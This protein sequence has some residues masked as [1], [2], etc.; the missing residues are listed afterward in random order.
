MSTIKHAA[1]LIHM[2]QHLRKHNN[3]QLKCT[4]WLKSKAAYTGLKFIRNHPFF[5]LWRPL[6]NGIKGGEVSAFT[7]LATAPCQPY[8]DA[9]ADGK[10]YIGNEDFADIAQEMYYDDYEK[11]TDAAPPCLSTFYDAQHVTLIKATK[12]KC[13][14]RTTKKSGVYFTINAGDEDL[15]ALHKEALQVPDPQDIY[16]E[17]DLEATGMTEEQ[18][19]AREELATEFLRDFLIP[20]MTNSM[21]VRH[22]LATTLLDT[23]T[24]QREVMR[25]HKEIKKYYQD[26]LCPAEIVTGL[27]EA[28]SDDEDSINEFNPTADLSLDGKDTACAHVPA[29]K[30]IATMFS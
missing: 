12:L 16:G 27:A 18:S 9:D 15:H 11:R 29:G 13:D 20:E 22:G 8:I 23:D 2:M 6:I 7:K 1:K 28:P 25:L 30:S 24:A 26:P 4:K 17:V 10:I 5:V 3:N 21:I 14:R 19:K